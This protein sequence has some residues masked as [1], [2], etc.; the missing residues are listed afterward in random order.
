MKLEKKHI[1]YII[2]AAIVLLVIIIIAVRNKRAKEAALNAQLQSSSTYNTDYS[3]P[4]EDDG[5]SW[6]EI[7]MAGFAP[8]TLLF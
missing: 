4:V 1:T 5:Y 3:G 6:G 8:W 2:I 7:W